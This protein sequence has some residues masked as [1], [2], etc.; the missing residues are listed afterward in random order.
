[1][2]KILFVLAIGLSVFNAKAQMVS[3]SESP[4]G[5]TEMLPTYPGGNEALQRFV[6][7]KLSVS[8]IRESERQKGTVI[9]YFMVDAEGNPSDHQ[10]LSGINERYDAL[11]LETVRKI[12]RWNAG[13][14]GTT[15]R[16]M[17]QKVEIRF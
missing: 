13:R 6:N 5:A 15:P 2:K 10:V 16:I 7:K 4:A 12:K 9:V 3:Y 14:F 17:G 1:M 8:G 11:A